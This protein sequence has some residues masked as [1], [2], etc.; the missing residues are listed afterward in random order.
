M[1]RHVFL[2]SDLFRKAQAEVPPDAREKVRVAVVA[3]RSDAG[4]C[5][6]RSAGQ[7]RVISRDEKGAA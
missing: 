7:S 5:P 1:G 2:G 3:T 4:L 6:S